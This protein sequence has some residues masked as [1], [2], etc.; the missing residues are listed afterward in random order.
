MNQKWDPLLVAPAISSPVPS[1]RAGLSFTLPARY[2]TSPE[3]F[4][5]EMERFYF[6]SWICAGRAERIPKPGD[7]FLRNFAGESLIVTR[8]AAGAIRAFFN[9]CRHRGTRICT[10]P[11]GAFAGRIACPYHGWTYALDGSL[12][13]APHMEQ[14]GFSRADYPLRAVAA[15]VWDGHIFLHCGVERQPLAAQISGLPGKFAAWRMEELRLQRRITYDVKA[16]WKLLVS[17]YNECVHCP[18][19]H[20]AL[21]R[22][23]DYLGADNEAP[24]PG[25]IG[26]AMG[27]R[28]GA[29]T[30]T[31][32]GIRRRDYLPGLDAAQRRMVYYYAIFPNFLLSLHPDYMMTHTLW[33]QSV[34]RTEVICE[35][36][37]HPD[38]MAKPDFQADDAIEFWDLTNRQD[39]AIVEMSQAGI[40]SR[41]YSPGPYSPREDLLRAFDE[42]VL[43]SLEK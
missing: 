31:A 23:T 4:R 24:T 35:W 30:M 17:N 3:I 28:D 27:F 19:I 10:V 7:Y 22:L 15:D 5:A 25:Y 9:V 12:L 16:N 41:G 1:D 29:E 36:H 8:D 38:E 34:D 6:G 26:G 21:N 40:Q 39:W 33:P 14:P 32:D 42:W 11:E 20:P 37:F 13:G 18:F 2:Y 43:G